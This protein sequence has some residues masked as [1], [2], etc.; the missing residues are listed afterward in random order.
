MLSRKYF[1]F[2]KENVINL[3][4]VMYISVSIRNILPVILNLTFDPKTVKHCWHFLR[5][6]RQNHVCGTTE[7]S[8]VKTRSVLLV[9]DFLKWTNSFSY[10]VVIHIRSH[11]VSQTVFT[12]DQTHRNIVSANTLKWTFLLRVPESFSSRKLSFIEQLVNKHIM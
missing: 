11:S 6:W 7:N 9:T 1:T 12:M 8:A 10:S 2:R 5:G 3:L 4:V